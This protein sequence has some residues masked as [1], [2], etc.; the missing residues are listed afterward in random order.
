MEARKKFNFILQNAIMKEFFELQSEESSLFFRNHDFH[1]TNTL[2][3]YKI[4]QQCGCD[5]KYCSH[6]PC[7]SGICFP[8][9]APFVSYRKVPRA[10]IAGRP[11]KPT[12]VKPVSHKSLQKLYTFKLKKRT[13]QD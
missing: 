11:I 8:S 6:Y 13:P 10:S 5:K 9:S 2:P 7:R 4:K 3:F 12:D 1:R